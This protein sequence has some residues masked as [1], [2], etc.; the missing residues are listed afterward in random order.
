MTLLISSSQKLLG[1]ILLNNKFDFDEYVTS[2][3]RKASQKLNAFFFVFFS[4]IT[5]YNWKQK[6]NQKHTTVPQYQC[7][8]ML[9][10]N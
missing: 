3:C 1:M 2:L 7:Y 10:G 9:G 6:I 8:V 5:I 4:L